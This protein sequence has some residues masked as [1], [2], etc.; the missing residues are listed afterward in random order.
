MYVTSDVAEG[1]MYLTRISEPED[2]WLSHDRTSDCS[3]SAGDDVS[4]ELSCVI[5]SDTLCLWL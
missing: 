4:M 2:Y 3:D 5:G 1:T